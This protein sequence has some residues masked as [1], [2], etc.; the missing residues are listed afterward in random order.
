M[1]HRLPVLTALFVALGTIG[2]SGCASAAAP[3]PLAPWTPV[4]A[5][6]L[7]DLAGGKTDVTHLAEG[8]VA[9]VSLW[10]TWCEACRKEFDALNR[11]NASTAAG[12]DALVIAID[13]GEDR[14]TVA[15]F[16]RERGLRY[17]QLVDE[18]FVFADALGQRRV[19]ATLVVDRH[20]HIVFRG[21]ALDTASL[22]AMRRAISEAQA[23]SRSE[24]PS[25]ATAR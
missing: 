23:S 25:G 19:P 16:A 22:E 6:E 8:R 15:S 2:A 4:P 11:L 24:Y 14:D 21:D 20:G 13:V 1:G 3:A 10:A 7:T 9:L 18:D 5:V 17:A 12:R